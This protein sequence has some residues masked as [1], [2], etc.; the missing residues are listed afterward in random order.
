MMSDVPLRSTSQL[1]MVLRSGTYF[2]F[3]N[4]GFIDKQMIDVA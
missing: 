4:P 1:F 3:R 2:L